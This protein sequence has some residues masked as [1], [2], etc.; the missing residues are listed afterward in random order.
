MY[1]IFMAITVLFGVS[2]LY[3]ETLPLASG[4]KASIWMALF[5][6]AVIGVF[7][8]YL[9]S[10]KV[11]SLT[12]KFQSMQQAQ[13]EMELRQNVILEVI[14]ER[15]ETSTHGIRRHREVFE[16][17][18]QG[19]MDPEVMRNEM[20][21]FRRDES[22]LVDALADLNDFALIRSGTLPL[23]HTAFD[24][25]DVLSRL[26]RQVEPHY[27]LKRNEL[28]YRF[29]PKMIG[30]VVGDMQRIEQILSTFLIE[31]GRVTYDG[32]VTLSMQPSPAGDW[33][34][35]DLLAPP[36]DES[37][38]MLDD[39]FKDE[40]T[41]VQDATQYSS[42]KLKNYLARELIG[43]MGGSLKAVADHSLGIHY[44]MELPLDVE[45]TLAQTRRTGAA[46][47]LVVAH[48]DAVA[49]SVSDMLAW[50]KADGVDLL[51]DSEDFVSNLSGYGTVVITYSALSEA[52][53][54]QLR[55]AQMKQPLRIIV[56]KSGF[57]RTL[58]L[59]ATLED[60]QVLKL[61]LLPE[62]LAAALAH[63]SQSEMG[64]KRT[65]S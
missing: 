31:L 28:V 17:Q 39:I 9:S 47:T 25:K 20:V 50:R 22:L 8:L 13:R 16:E 36:N 27:F 12:K 54:A 60:V 61:P 65:A 40:E 4:D 42:R 46:P 30:S 64:E 3:A 57:Q 52:W 6:L 43:L 5:G 59:P 7:L 38:D 19:E 44:R 11:K 1:R 23:T 14:G 29:N 53:I 49:L 34:T 21:R 33:V 48:N 41:D 26:G 45:P 18:T 2:G 62:E 24:L 37:I 63:T 15:L 56:L 35:F 58:P 32:T 51:T 10:E 55:E